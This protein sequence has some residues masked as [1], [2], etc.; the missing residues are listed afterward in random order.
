MY[1]I[2]MSMPL[3]NDATGRRNNFGLLRVAFATLVIV[4]HSS[5]LVDGNRS[6]ELMTRVFGT[7]SLGDLAVDGF[8]IISGYLISKSFVDRES[9]GQFLMRRISRIVPAFAVSFWLCVFLLAP[10]VGAGRTVATWPVLRYQLARFLLLMPP[11]V[12][13]VFKG[14]AYPT[15]DA[16]MWTISYEF[17]CYLATMAIGVLGVLD[18]RMRFVW[19][20]ITPTMVTLS[21]MRLADYFGG[22]L[23]DYIL[24]SLRFGAFYSVGITYFLFRDRVPLARNVAVIAAVVLCVL[25]FDARTAEAAVAIAGGYLV[26]WFAL[27]VPEWRLSRAVNR[28]DLSYGVYLYAWPVQSLVI[29]F[30]RTI[31]PWLLCAISLSLTSALAFVSWKFVEKPV[32]QFAHR[33]R[34]RS[35]VARTGR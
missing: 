6:R 16:S 31:N 5:E 19:L 13:N 29:W 10:W 21:A 4:A 8:F 17:A 25:L 2:A 22:A 9:T 12:H 3:A 20:V 33:G 1:D 32:L 15:L 11:D 7:M 14:L 34:E 24:N 35:G 26:F 28:T 30:D 27:Q 18:R 23:H